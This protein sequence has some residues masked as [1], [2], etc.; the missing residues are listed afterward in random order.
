MKHKI[1]FLIIICFVLA[2]CRVTLITGYDQVLDETLTKMKN[3]FNLHFIKLGRTIQD[4]NPDNQKWDNFLTY[5]DQLAVDT[6]IIYDRSQTLGRKSQIVKK[7]IGNVNSAFRK[8]M[9]DHKAGLQDRPNDPR[10]DIQKAI[11]TA[12]NATLLLQEELKTT[13]KIT[14]Q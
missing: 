5:Y 6:L 8:L 10:T 2:G 12:I 9:E 7:Q 13:G 11:N 4:N 1:S 14:S 3:D